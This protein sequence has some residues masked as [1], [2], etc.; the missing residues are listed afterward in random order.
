LP[1]AGQAAAQLAA[2]VGDLL[3]RASPT[4]GRAAHVGQ[5]AVRTA[6]KAAPEAEASAMCEAMAGVVRERL[7][8]WIYGTAGEL[9]ED[10]VT[11]LLAKQGASVAT[12][13]VGTGGLLASRLCESPPEHT[14]RVT[15]LGAYG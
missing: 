9:L 12:V 3:T 2:R 11:G 13:E 15:C 8:P 14:G 1:T 6:A 5:T 7:G 10:V 4:G